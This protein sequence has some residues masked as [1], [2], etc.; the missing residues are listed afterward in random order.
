MSG[1]TWVAKNCKSPLALDRY[2]GKWHSRI[3]PAASNSRLAALP[4]SAGGRV[5]RFTK[6]GGL[7]WGRL[8][9]YI[10]PM[11]KFSVDREKAI[12]ALIYVAHVTGKVGRFH[13]AIILYFAD[14]YHLRRYGRPVTGDFYV[15]MENGPV[16]SFAYNVLKGSLSP[17]QQLL[18]RGALEEVRTERHP[19]YRAGREPN[20]KYFSQTDMECLDDAIKYCM[21][22]T[23]GQIS[24]ETHK[25]P[26]WQRA[27]LNDAMSFE[28][29][30]D[31]APPDIV[32]EAK[33]FAAYGVL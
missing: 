25:H 18:A 33:A 19:V 31:G 24:D 1:A 4:P 5:S 23:F 28:D 16:P 29:M 21:P 26:A 8:A 30:L 10:Q 3:G 32:E 15:A 2:S 14:L 12:E 7:S 17:A 9:V 22:K 6:R 13:A 20:L 11:I 27:A